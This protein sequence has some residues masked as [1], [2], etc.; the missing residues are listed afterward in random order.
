MI[1]KRMSAMFINQILTIS[2]LRF[3]CICKAVYA[4]MNIKILKTILV[5]IALFNHNY[6][7][8]N[9][10]C[11]KY[12]SNLMSKNTHHKKQ[13]HYDVDNDDI[14]E[15]LRIIEKKF[16]KINDLD[17]SSDAPEKIV[18][19]FCDKLLVS[20]AF[21]VYYRNT[22]DLKKKVA[23]LKQNILEEY[24]T[25]HAVRQ[26]I[27][28]VYKQYLHID[29][30]SNCYMVYDNFV[31]EI[32]SGQINISVLYNINTIKKIYHHIIKL[33]NSIVTFYKTYNP[34]LLRN[35]DDKFKEICDIIFDNTDISDGAYKEDKS[36]CVT[37]IINIMCEFLKLLLHISQQNIVNG[38]CYI[39]DACRIVDSCGNIIFVPDIVMPNK[40]LKSYKR[41][42]QEEYQAHEL[43]NLEDAMGFLHI[44][45]IPL[46]WITKH[47]TKYKRFV[48][49][50]CD[51]SK[52]NV[53]NILLHECI[54]YLKHTIPS[55]QEFGTHIIHMEKINSVIKNNYF[56][57]HLYAANMHA[58]NI[59]YNSIISNRRTKDQADFLDKFYQNHTSRLRVSNSRQEIDFKMFMESEYI[60]NCDKVNVVS[61]ILDNIVSSIKNTKI[62][63]VDQDVKN[64]GALLNIS[65]HIYIN[66]GFKET[67]KLSGIKIY[68]SKAVNGDSSVLCPIDITM[69]LA[70]VHE[71]IHLIHYCKYGNTSTSTKIADTLSQYDNYST[72]YTNDEEVHTIFGIKDTNIDKENANHDKAMEIIIEN[73]KS[74]RNNMQNNICS[75]KQ[76]QEITLIYDFISEKGYI[77]SQETTNAREMYGNTRH[78]AQ[79]TKED[80]FR[81]V[82]CGHVSYQKGRRI[83]LKV[84][85]ELAK[86]W[87]IDIKRN[88][89]GSFMLIN[90]PKREI[91]EPQNIIK[92]NRGK[93]WGTRRQ[94]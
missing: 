20:G 53:G 38:T 88:K 78:I 75:N 33:L 16:K 11:N 34:K 7:C 58:L 3:M 64:F 42:M 79:K 83:T 81:V 23:S 77:D 87:G 62:N 29:A 49:A 84:A 45:R 70:I 26:N 48:Q 86:Q 2:G 74:D 56:Y 36:L 68:N 37:K 30:I 51:I 65:N 55:A 28:T 4:F 71:L 18:D 73:Y 93:I 22:A 91:Q 47:K 24:N 66:L 69:E 1:K 54:K 31:H 35:M 61:S 89:N 90:R 32:T 67:T 6:T 63:F 27:N 92:I 57:M 13:I 12:I 40:F 60:D 52:N 59:I 94:G 8:S 76:K 82:R 39:D 17:M 5:F 25:N 50:I 44:T 46:E 41:T 9:N 19:K 85:E 72:I 15:I 10:T 80:E 43:H 14:G 21:A